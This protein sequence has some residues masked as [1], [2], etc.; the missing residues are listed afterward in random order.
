ML[1]NRQR[2]RER[3]TGIDADINLTLID[4]EW[5]QADDTRWRELTHR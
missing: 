5:N 1:T 2:E 4:V 3:E